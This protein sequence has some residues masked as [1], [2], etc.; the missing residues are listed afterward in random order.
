MEGSRVSRNLESD[1]KVSESMTEESQDIVVLLQPDEAAELASQG[2]ELAIKQRDAAVKQVQE[3]SAEL[4][5]PT[6]PLFDSTEDV[7]DDPTVGLQDAATTLAEVRKYVGGLTK[8]SVMSA[9][10]AKKPADLLTKL[11]YFRLPR[12][13]KRGADGVF[14]PAEFVA[15]LEKATFLDDLAKHYFVA[16]NQITTDV[17]SFSSSWAS[18]AFESG[19]RNIQ[20]SLSASYGGA[21]YGVGAAFSASTSSQH[22]EK[23]DK[24]KKT[25]YIAGV[26]EVQKL[27]IFIPP[28]LIVLADHV[29]A[30]FAGAITVL[31]AEDAKDKA[32]TKMLPDERAKRA[33]LRKHAKFV[34]LFDEYGYFVVTHY[35]IGGKLSSS[36]TTTYTDDATRETEANSRKH[37]PVRSR[38]AKGDSPSRRPP[39]MGTEARRTRRLRTRSR[40]TR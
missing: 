26:Y 29:T 34:E 21:G 35:T 32:D 15:T 2:R 3:L 38:R 18:K 16:V 22:A 8:D 37:S 9:L 11:T 20:A 23:T 33:L 30:A 13:V 1:K 28:H 5:R 27:R 4:G 19:F 6:K 39:G 24:R 10:A 7:I 17:R 36:E 25:A 31:K 12:T 14:V 40:A